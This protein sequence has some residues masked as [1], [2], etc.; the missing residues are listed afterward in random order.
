MGLI[1]LNHHLERKLGSL[2]FLMNFQ[3]IGMQAH[4]TFTVQAHN[5]TLRLI[6]VERGTHIEY[7]DIQLYGGASWLYQW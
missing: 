4:V 1:D 7:L 2:K 6:V 5:G 3:V